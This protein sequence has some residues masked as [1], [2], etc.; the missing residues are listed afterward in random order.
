[1]AK[2]KTDTDT[3]FESD[4]QREELS[5]LAPETELE[6]EREPISNPLSGVPFNAVLNVG[7]ILHYQVQEGMAPLPA[8]VS[9]MNTDGTVDVTVFRSS[10]PEPRRRVRV[11]DFPTARACNWPA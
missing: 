5:E 3:E 9:A 10:G 11:A 4:Q 2:K 7:S 6:T 8:I 1:M